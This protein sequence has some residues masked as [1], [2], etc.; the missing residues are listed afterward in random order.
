MTII[1]AKDPIISK[2]WAILRALKELENIPKTSVEYEKDSEGYVLKINLKN[3]QEYVPDFE[4]QWCPNK[5]HFRAYILVG[6]TD[7]PKV[8]IGYSIFVLP[9]ALAAFAFTTVYAFIHKYR[10]NNKSAAE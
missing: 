8:N 2:Q 9:T 7:Y 5:K 6:N 3:K 10:A 4:F 1:L